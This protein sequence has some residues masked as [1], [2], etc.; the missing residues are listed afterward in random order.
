MSGPSCAAGGASTGAAASRGAKVRAA[1]MAA[2]RRNFIWSV[3]LVDAHWL[4]CCAYRGK[5]RQPSSALADARARQFALKLGDQLRN[6]LAERP[7][8]LAAAMFEHAA[9]VVDRI[10]VHRSPAPT[11]GAHDG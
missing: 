1:A 2:S 9:P 7:C 6:R 8:F 11:P 5:P 3:P 4:A 10:P